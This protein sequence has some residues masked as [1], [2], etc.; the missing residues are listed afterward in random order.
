MQKED[1][2]SCWQFWLNRLLT[3]KNKNTN[4]SIEIKMRRWPSLPSLLLLLL[5]LLR[6]FEGLALTALAF[7]D[8][9]VEL[10]G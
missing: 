9:L 3:L 7:V 6:S 4:L 2:S 1:A 8:D 5:L 10:A